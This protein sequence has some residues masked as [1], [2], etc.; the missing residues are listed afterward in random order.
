MADD[1]KKP[2]RVKQAEE[3]RKNYSESEKDASKKGVVKIDP[4]GKWP[5][6]PPPEKGRK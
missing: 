1:N 4:E 5:P 3:I 6:P 2:G